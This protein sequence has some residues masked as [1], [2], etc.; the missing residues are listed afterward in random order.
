M[1]GGLGRGGLRVNLGVYQKLGLNENRGFQSLPVNT[2]MNLD[3][4]LY[5][6]IEWCCA[7]PF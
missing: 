4:S 6:R 3:S 1:T 7:L 5:R 2:E